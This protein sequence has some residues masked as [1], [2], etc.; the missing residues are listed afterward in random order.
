MTNLHK[1][2]WLKTVSSVHSARDHALWGVA[3]QPVPAPCHTG[4]CS[5]E[6]PGREAAVK[7]LRAR[8]G[9]RRWPVVPPQVLKPLGSCK[10][11]APPSSAPASPGAP[12]R[13][14]GSALNKPPGSPLSLPP[15]RRVPGACGLLA[16]RCAARAGLVLLRGDEPSRCTSSPRR[17]WFFTR[18]CPEERE[19]LER[20]RC[21]LQ[22]S[23]DSSVSKA[24]VV[25]NKRPARADTG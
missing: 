23:P 16:P 3:E 4:R 1:A 11:S 9:S 8:L 5:S 13:R 17:L 14:G 20:R 6:E 18:L 15:G 7:P 2:R 21:G 25:P 19:L 24:N 12:C 22:A 10:A